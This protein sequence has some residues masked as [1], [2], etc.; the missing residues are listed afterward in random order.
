ML[1]KPQ[2]AYLYKTALSLRLLCFKTSKAMKH[3]QRCRMDFGVIFY[4]G[5]PLN[6]KTTPQNYGFLKRI[7]SADDV[8][9]DAL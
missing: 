4:E 1:S 7:T 5:S 8:F 2:N 3:I 9:L 6:L